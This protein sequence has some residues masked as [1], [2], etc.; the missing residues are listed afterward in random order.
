MKH[1]INEKLKCD[2]SALH[3]VSENSDTHKNISTHS[4]LNIRLGQVVRRQERAPWYP[5]TGSQVAWAS[6]HMAEKWISS[7][8][9]N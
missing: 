4:N 2:V 3:Q 7:R 8:L 5:M 9:R 1:V 6:L